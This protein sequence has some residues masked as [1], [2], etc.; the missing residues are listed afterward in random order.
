M[1]GV[2]NQMRRVLAVVVL[3]V[4]GIGGCAHEWRSMEDPHPATVADMNGVLRDQW[5]RHLFWI[6]NVVLDRSTNDLRSRDFAEKAVVANARELARTFRPFYGEAA[7][8]RLFTLL[9]DHYSAVKEYSEATVARNKRQ[10]DEALA[11]FALNTDEIAA[12]LSGANPYLPKDTVRGLIATHVDHH[13]AQIIKFQEKDYAGEEE[14]WPVMQHHI[15]VIA[16][17]LTTALAKQF[18]AKFS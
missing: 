13:V 10:Q 8:E 2:M 6:R 9:A 4:V 16:D 3:A 12:F 15:Y 5:S 7:S 18:P 14:T 17:A 11:H 1:E